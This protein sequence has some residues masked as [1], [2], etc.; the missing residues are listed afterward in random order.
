M[1]DQAAR[2][3]TSS[4]KA[5]TRALQNIAPLDRYNADTLGGRVDGLAERFGANAALIS[6]HDNVT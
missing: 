6:E 4:I 1:L 2:P 5:W 3:R